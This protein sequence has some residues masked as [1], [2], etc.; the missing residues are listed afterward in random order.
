MKIKK[1]SQLENNNPS[2]IREYDP[3]NEVWITIDKDKKPKDGD[4]VMDEDGDTH[5][6]SEKEGNIY[7]TIIGVVIKEEPGTEEDYELRLDRLERLEEN[8]MEELLTEWEK[9]Y[10][11]IDLPEKIKSETYYYDNPSASIE[12]IEFLLEVIKKLR[13]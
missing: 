5:T 4:V 12:D 8:K 10:I 2:I 11:S 1:F 6:F 7:G 13:S 9:E 3:R